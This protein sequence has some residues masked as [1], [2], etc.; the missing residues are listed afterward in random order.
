MN[1]RTSRN[2]GLRRAAALAAVVAVAVLATAC[3]GSAPAA[4]SAPT[5]AQVLALVRCMRGHGVPGFPD[6]DPSGGY[7]LMPN[8]SLTGAGGASVDINST[9]AQAAYGDCRHLVPGGPSISRLEQLEQEEQQRQAQLLPQLLKYVQCMRGHGV[10]NFPA[11]GQSKTGPGGLPNVNSPQYVAAAS[12]CQHL[13]P[14]GA[15]VNISTGGSRS[16]S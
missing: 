10:P 7:S 14:P 1:D 12:V 6:P 8:G 13:L 16:S 9:Q 5:Y 11:P 4:K 15:K 2:R 3:G